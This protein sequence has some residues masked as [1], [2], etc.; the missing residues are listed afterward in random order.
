M[1]A[2]RTRCKGFTLMEILVVIAIIVVLAAIAYP[3]YSRIK[4]SSNKAN[5]LNTM[6]QLSATIA[7]Y[8]AE[9]DGDLPSEDAEGQDDWKVVAEPAS[10][11][12]WYNAL[13]RQMRQKSAGDFAREKRF[14]AFYTREN[15]LYL[16]GASYPSE[17]KKLERPLFPIS[18]NTKI[19]R[20][21]KAK[22]GEEDGKK[23]AIKLAAVLLQGQTVAFT[24]QGLPGE[25]KAHDSISVK[26]DYDGSPKGSA[27]SFVTRYGE[28][29]VIAFFD[30]HAI[31]VKASDILDNAG[32]IRWQDDWH[33]A[34]PAGI[35]W[36]A[37]PKE[38]PNEKE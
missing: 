19:H 31:E 37:D 16:P 26:D 28:K 10:D 22:A 11:T 6:H 15:F 12:A 27:K 36:T 25:P 20:K 14:L 9:N 2:L 38:D 7:S 5:A 17:S 21:K 34:N 33:T 13:L 32:R 29:G 35:F 8:V 1:K 23:P 24:E 3:V 30:G 18:M 4:S